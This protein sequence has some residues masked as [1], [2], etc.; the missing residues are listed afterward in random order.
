MK[1]LSAPMIWASGGVCP[2]PNWMSVDKTVSITTA[3]ASSMTVMPKASC[4]SGRWAV[5]S[6]CRTL[7]IMAELED[8]QHAR[9]KQAFGMRPTRQ[10]PEPPAAVED[11][12]SPNGCRQ[13]NRKAQ[14][15]KPLK[16]QVQTD[17]KDKKD[18]AE[19]GEHLNAIQ[20]GNELEGRRMRTDNGPHRQIADHKRKA[21]A[22]ANPADDPGD[23]HDHSQIADEID[24]CHRVLLMTR[25]SVLLATIPAFSQA[26]KQCIEAGS[27]SHLGFYR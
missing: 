20:I 3:T 18:Q 14:P 2:P 21:K 16:A 6:S 22:L 7:L 13:H 8:H 27:N 26:S 12:D 15:P 10:R 11:K 24:S 19:L 1:A 17:R 4:P 9:E 23:S 5:L 25:E